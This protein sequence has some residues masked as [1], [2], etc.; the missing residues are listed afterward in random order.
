MFIEKSCI[1][2]VD[3]AGKQV[4]VR[5]D[6][7]VP[8]REGRVVDDERIRACLPTL[9]LLREQGCRLILASHLG[10]PRGRRVADLSLRPAARRL[11]ELLGCPVPLAPD[12]V[13]PQA[14]ALARKLGHGECLMLE[15]LRFHP[16]EAANDRDFC[17]Q[18]AAL[19]EVYVNE[20]FSASHRR[21]AS[22]AGIVEHVPLA[23]AGLLMKRE[24]EALSQI[25]LD[26]ARPYAAILGGAKV[27]DKVS[28]VETLL[29]KVDRLLIGG[30]MA[31]PFLAA[32][33][34]STGNSLLESQT[35]E[36][37]RALLEKAGELEVPLHLPVDHRVVKDPKLHEPAMDTRSEAIGDGYAAVDI[38]PRTEKLFADVLSNCRCVLWNGPLGFFE[39][40]Y[41]SGSR[42]VAEA[43]IASGAFSVA[44]GG[45]TA[46]VLH[47]LDLAGK[48]SH[49]STGGGASLEF[50]CG[51]TL[52]GI[53][54]LNDR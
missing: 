30:A 39:G 48:F 20:A 42:A 38:G 51:K 3:L 27:A 5:V 33:G 31:Y 28:L 23:V 13:G 18:L 16:E 19:G 8:L 46:A 36:T 6:F 52:P 14:E 44:G 54:A 15:N 49:L 1:D 50:L 32:R 40:G 24:I 26:P 12:C 47:A 29:L 10:R 11:A 43:V 21:H 45:D 22:V 35:V 41:V 2:E 17:R 34:I 37:A 4:L 53:Q 25:S 9:R 7:N